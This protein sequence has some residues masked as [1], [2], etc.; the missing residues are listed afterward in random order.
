MPIT[1]YK[2]DI[3]AAKLQ[4]KDYLLGRAGEFTTRLFGLFPHADVGEKRKLAK[5]FPAHVYVYMFQCEELNQ[6][7]FDVK[8]A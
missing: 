1:V 6:I 7:D 5:A 2:S 3:S 4:Y 8:E